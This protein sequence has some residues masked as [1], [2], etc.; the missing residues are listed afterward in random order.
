MHPA[1][2]VCE[3]AFFATSFIRSG[4]GK[5]EI[6]KDEQKDIPAALFFTGSREGCSA[7]CMSRSVASARLR[8]MGEGVRMVRKEL[9]QQVGSMKAA[10][11]RNPRI[12]CRGSL[13]T[14]HLLFAL[15]SAIV[16]GATVPCNKEDVKIEFP[17]SFQ[18]SLTSSGDVCTLKSSK[19]KQLSLHSYILP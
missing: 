11:T 17:T 15:K 7:P 13:H 16:Y 5:A 3:N 19:D 14:A 10:P 18:K 6:G 9:E 2:M 1:S 8:A 4:L 12:S